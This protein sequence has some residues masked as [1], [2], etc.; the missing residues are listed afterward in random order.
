MGKGADIAGAYKQ[1]G[2]YARSVDE[3]YLEPEKRPAEAFWAD[4]IVF[5]LEKRPAV[6]N[7][8]S[9]S[10]KGRGSWSKGF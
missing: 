8:E 2:G 6:T 10:P 5:E 4:K 9:W 1:V 7:I 3:L